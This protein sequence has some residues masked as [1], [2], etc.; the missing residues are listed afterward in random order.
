MKRISQR[1][2]A[3]KLGVNVSTI[4]R[5]LRGLEGVGEDLRQKI[6]SLAEDHGYRPN[7]F[8]ISLRYDTTHTI[9]IV[10]PDLSYNYYAQIVRRIEADARKQGFMCI[11]TDSGDSY[12]GEVEC[13]EHLEKLH[14]D[15]IIL[16]VSQETTNFSHL[17]RLKKNGIPVV[18]FERSVNANFSSVCINDYILTR[19][20]TLHL[21]DGGAKSIAFLGGP[22]TMNQSAERKH[23]YLEVL[24]ERKIPIRKEL[25]KCSP[26]SLN[27][28]LADT[29]DL[30]DLP[31]PPDAILATH[32]MLALSSIQAVLSRGLRVP[33]DI[34][35]IGFVSNWVSD[36]TNPRMTFVMQN[37]KEMGSKA[38]QL[39]ID[40]MNGDNSVQHVLVNARLEL[41]DSTKKIII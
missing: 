32:G 27:S 35:I 38:F 23:A 13:V 10:M 28:G 31:E 12:E 25:V 3:K 1:D 22:N 2:I 20:A 9:G 17:E 36:I 16:C 34:A 33:E 18:L 24:R 26:L 40:Q 4:S 8:A 15:G 21:I 41:R 37:M 7:P 6:M 5:A 29:L 30:L 39:L 19:Q 11:I 14:V